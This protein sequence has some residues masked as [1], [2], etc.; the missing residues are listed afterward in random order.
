[1]GV[2]VLCAPRGSAAVILRADAAGGAVDLD[3]LGIPL[4]VLFV[5]S[6]LAWFAVGSIVTRRRVA[7]AAR[8][9]N[10]GLEVYRD[11]SPK[12][13]KA[14]LKWLSPTAF[15]ILLDGPRAPFR[16][17]IATVLLQSRDMVTIWLMNR[18]TGRR[19]L[20]LLRFELRRQPIWGLEVF[21][22]RSLLAGDSR[23]LATQEG[24][25]LEPNPPHL[26]TA[27][28]GGKAGELCRALLDALGEER[29]RLVRLGVR[30]RAPHLTL[31]LDLP[32]PSKSDPAETMR[33]A[34]RLATITLAYSTP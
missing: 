8:W 21:R 19:D 3:N 2:G 12:G 6:F 27:H 24:W 31:A 10:R 25:P 26:L 16:G 20:L 9:V 7:A 28:G 30:R 11:E 14:S 34:E 29:R 13:S 22:A 4:T 23:R 5:A 17:V 1:L 32:D 33:L 15:N 18:L